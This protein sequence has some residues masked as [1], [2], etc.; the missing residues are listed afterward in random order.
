MRASSVPAKAKASIQRPASFQTI[1]KLRNSPNPTLAYLYRRFLTTRLLEGVPPGRFLEIGVGRGRFFED[2]VKLGFQGLCLDL[3]RELIAE[4]EKSES[5]RAGCVEF[6]AQNFFSVHERFD[7]IVGFE[8]LEHY[9]QDSD[10]LQKWVELL[11]PGGTL[12]FSVPAHM[13]Q[14][15]RNDTL[16]GH[17]R[18]YEK[19]E[20]VEKLE[21]CGFQ[22]ERLWCYGFPVLN[23]T[24]PLSSAFFRG[25]SSAVHVLEEGDARMTDFEKTTSSGSRRFPGFSDW[26]FREQVWFLCLHA[27]RPFL[28][29]DLGTGYLVKCSRRQV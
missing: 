2:L 9:A 26:L 18:R 20:L 11:K 19:K 22:V 7:L 13:R 14:W 25:S 28:R 1:R 17:A 12:V 6:K 10:C 15:T 29:S 27:Q 24:Y 3:N 8:V 21:N 5:F 4:H 23:M 16:A